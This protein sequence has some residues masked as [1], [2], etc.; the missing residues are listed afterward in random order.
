MEPIPTEKFLT[1]IQTGNWV[2]KVICHFH[3]VFLGMNLNNTLKIKER[4]ETEM[5]TD[6]TGQVGKSMHQ[7]TSSYQL[8]YVEGVL[9]GRQ[10]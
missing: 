8:K 5:N 10:F 6:I 9:N 7:S 2:K 3:K 1:K 4:W